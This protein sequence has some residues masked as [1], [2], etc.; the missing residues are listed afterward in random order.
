MGVDVAD[1]QAPETVLV[2][3]MQNFVLCC[4]GGF[5]KIG[6]AGQ[7]KVPSPEAAQGNFAD[8]EGMGENPA[9]IEV[10]RESFVSIP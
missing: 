4:N 5:G 7:D 6:Q 8:H 2:D 10:S 1:T 3:E 9:L